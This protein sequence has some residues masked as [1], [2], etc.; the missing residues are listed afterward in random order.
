V[1]LADSVAALE[2]QLEEALDKLDE[3][4]GFDSQS[5]FALDQLETALEAIADHKRG[6]ITLD[7]LYERTVGR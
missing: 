6:L 4:Q 7:E 3:L 5:A 2:D 1:S